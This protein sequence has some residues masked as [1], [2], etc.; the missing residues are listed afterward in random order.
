MA[1]ILSV[2]EA[3]AWLATRPKFQSQAN[4]LKEAAQALETAVEQVLQEGQVLTYD[5]IGEEK[6]SSGTQVT[7]AVIEHLRALLRQLSP[8]SQS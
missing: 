2:K 8:A 4:S 7:V 1:T 6:A 3:L 5:L